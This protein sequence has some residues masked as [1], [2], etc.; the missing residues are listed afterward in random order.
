MTEREKTELQANWVFNGEGGTAI[1][2]RFEPLFIWVGET[3]N[4]IAVKGLKN[5]AKSSEPTLFID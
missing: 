5:G 2:V 3:D 1:C 4:E